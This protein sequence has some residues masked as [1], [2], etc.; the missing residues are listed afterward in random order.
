MKKFDIVKENRELV[1][2]GIITET[3]PGVFKVDLI[4]EG[5]DA[6]LFNLTSEKDAVD[7]VMRHLYEVFARPNGEAYSIHEK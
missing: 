2:E 1:G 6:H 5:S 7:K 4:C 3:G